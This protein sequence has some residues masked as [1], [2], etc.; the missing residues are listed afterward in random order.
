MVRRSRGSRSAHGAGAPAWA[1]GGRVFLD[2]TGDADVA[3]LAGEPMLENEIDG[4]PQPPT[5][6]F[7]VAGVASDKI[8]WPAVQQLWDDLRPAEKWINPRGGPA[9]SPPFAYPGKPGFHGLNVTRSLGIDAT[10]TEDLVRMEIEQR[11]QVDEFLY[12]FLRRHVP[13]FKD[14]FLTGTHFISGIR[15]SR[16]IRAD[17]VLTAEPLRRQIEFPDAVGWSSYPIDRHSPLEGSTDWREE[18]A[19]KPGYYSI[20]FRIMVPSRTRNLLVSGRCVSAD[21]MAFSAIRVMGTTMALGEAAG[22]AAA[23][24]AREGFDAKQVPVER[25][26]EILR[27]RGAVTERCS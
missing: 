10:R 4:K 2:C 13:A 7:F 12:R 24:M 17:Y 15:E 27:S 25:V 26:R 22:V 1:V 18:E 11:E 19:K 16:R 21:E 6:L 8:D 20:P 9:L 3:W 23:L 14:A 5:L